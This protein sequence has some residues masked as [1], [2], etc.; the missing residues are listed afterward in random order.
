[1]SSSINCVSS[2]A[3][4]CPLIT[5]LSKDFQ[6]RSTRRCLLQFQHSLALP[7][8]RLAGLS[9]VAFRQGF[10]PHRHGLGQSFSAHALDLSDFPLHQ[11]VRNRSERYEMV[12]IPTNQIEH[13]PRAF[14]IFVMK[15]LAGVAAHMANCL[16]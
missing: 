15:A 10:R 2:L 4:T 9:P 8:Q 7:Q 16:L 5:Y 11:S 13:A 1:M 12:E 3:D 6:G 14:A